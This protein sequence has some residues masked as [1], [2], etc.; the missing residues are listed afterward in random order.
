[1]RN[2]R[3]YDAYKKAL[4]V[5]ATVLRA[6][7]A[8]PSHERYEISSQLR[9]AAVSVPSNIAEGAGRNSGKSFHHFLSIA[10][11]SLHEIEVQ[12]DISEMLGYL[13]DQQRSHIM[14]QLDGAI[15]SVLGLMKAVGGKS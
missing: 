14:N 5:S 9:R 4:S 8:F 15:R 10:L 3:R 11:G 1:M 13:M 2:F 12:I 7:D 6:T